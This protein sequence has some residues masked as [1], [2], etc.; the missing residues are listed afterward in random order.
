MSEFTLFHKLYRSYIHFH[1]NHFHLQ[2]N[3]V[4]I[5]LLIGIHIQLFFVKRISQFNDLY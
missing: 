3:K 4:I 2:Y 1:R 5:N